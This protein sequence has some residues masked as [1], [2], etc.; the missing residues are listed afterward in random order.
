MW[1]Q[2]NRQTFSLRERNV[3]TSGYV[4]IERETIAMVNK[5]GP[6]RIY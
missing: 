5:E 1:G 4:G 6:V 2:E 3:F